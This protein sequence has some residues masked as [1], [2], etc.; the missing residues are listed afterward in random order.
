VIRRAGRYA[1]IGIV[2][3]LLLAPAAASATAPATP[4]IT[5]PL[6]GQV[7]HPA[8]V[9][10]E[11]T[12]FSDAD[13]DT[14]QCSDWQILLEGAPVW[15]ADCATGVD[16]IHIHLAD[17]SYVG[18]YA[19]HGQLEFD[20]QYTLQV[21]FED[22]ANEF[23]AFAQHGFRTSPPGSPGGAVSWTPLQAGYE[24][25]TVAGDLQLPVDIAFVPDPGSKP[26]SPVLYITELYGT[27]KVISRDG[28]VSD[29]A[30]DLLNFNPTG[31]FPGSGEQGLAGIAVDPAS[32]DV[33]ASLLYDSDGSDATPNDHYPEVLRFHSTDGGRTAATTTPL[34]R[35]EMV[36]ETQGASHQI[37]NL[38][39]GPDGKLYVHMGDGFFTTPA[40]DPDSFRGK[41]LRVNTD[42]SAPSDNPFYDAGDG[43]DGAEDYIFALGFRN[44]FGGA[45]RAA[46]NAHYEVEN[47]LNAN[48]RF[49]RVEAGQNFGWN[50]NDSSMLTHALYSWH[51]PH[52]PVNIAFVQEQTFGGSG[53]PAAQQ[54][55]A[56]VTE[57]GP[58]YATGPQVRGKR[59]VEFDPQPGSEMGGHPRTLVEYTGDGKATALGLAAGLDGLYWTELYKDL[60]YTTPIDPGARLLRL[61][62][63]G[64]GPSCTSLGPTLKVAI[65]SGKAS[66]LARRADGEI[67]TDGH[68]CGPA[69]DAVEAIDVTGAGGAE[70]LTVDLGNGG[71]APGRTGEPGQLPEIELSL[72]LGAGNDQ[73]VIDGGSAPDR[74]KLVQGGAFLDRDGDLDLSAS[75]VERFIVRGRG[76][77]DRLQGG[78]L[79]DLL[80]GGPGRDWLRGGAG[81][82]VLVGRSQRDRFFGGPGRDRCDRYRRERARSCE[83]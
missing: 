69:V 43:T 74:I 9:H 52:A 49:A 16:A 31:N 47:A 53:F 18:A 38:S 51:P 68:S 57:S 63:L 70:R 79:P 77:P 25:E 28:T 55:R 60:D 65:P 20:H 76:G 41:I 21:R 17:G 72:D 62:Y 45:W 3:G 2:L 81:D 42:G 75:G 30:D 12:G 33:F 59:I 67:T 4:T 6:E 29:Y 26:G 48:D 34:L 83:L 39:F 50:G 64:G 80:F 27:I 22:S 5:S 82:D 71:L 78:P 15:R 35:D 10:M 73:L 23:S 11:A 32:G 40:L 44:P 37:S 24:V 14:H 7:V 8:D 13:G 36:G 66:T 58:T 19:G 56:F 54:D 61:R 1:A 46:N